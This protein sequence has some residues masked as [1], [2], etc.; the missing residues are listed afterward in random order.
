VADTAA[1]EE[2]LD[3]LIR[4]T[5]VGMLGDK[6]GV[7][8]IRLLARAGLDTDVIAD[9]VG[10]TPATVRA[11]RSRSSRKAGTARRKPRP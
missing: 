7:E 9:V 5:A 2:K 10:T 1:L 11:A 4:L 6:T 8:A 3:A